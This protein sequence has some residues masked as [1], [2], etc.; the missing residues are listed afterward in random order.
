MLVVGVAL[1]V[2][3][4]TQDDLKKIPNYPQEWHLHNDVPL[5]PGIMES[6]GCQ[7]KPVDDLIPGDIVVFKIGRVASHLGIVLDY[8]EPR[9]AIHAYSGSVS[10]VT[11][12]SLTG[13]WHDRI[14][15]AYTFPG[16]E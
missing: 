4:I 14:I 11:I 16:V 1:G 5:L 12:N 8:P 2:G 15:G 3:L 9:K 13:K 6:F 7:T 10:R